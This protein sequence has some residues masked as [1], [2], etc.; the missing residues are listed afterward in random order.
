MLSLV[1]IH[2]L[3]VATVKRNMKPK[4][5]GFAYKKAT[6]EAARQSANY[7]MF[8]DRKV[9]ENKLKVGVKL[10][11]HTLGPKGKVKIADDWEETPYIV[12]EVPKE[13]IPVLQNPS[14]EW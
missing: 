10:L 7:K 8:Y 4:F 5:L 14:R 12:L 9:R 1:W 13:D 11:I 3:K 6:E 2:L